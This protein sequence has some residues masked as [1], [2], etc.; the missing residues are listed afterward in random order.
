MKNVSTTTKNNANQMSENELVLALQH[1]YEFIQEWEDGAS[2]YDTRYWSAELE[3]A[4]RER[5]GYSQADID[6]I[7]DDAEEAASLAGVN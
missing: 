6:L 7:W 5:F 3:L 4:L 1:E 2:D